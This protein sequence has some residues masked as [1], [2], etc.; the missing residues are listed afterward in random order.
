MSSV[1]NKTSD[2]ANSNSGRVERHKLAD[3]LY[4]W[5]MA[6][7]VVSLMTTAF[8]PILGIKFELSW[9]SV[10]PFI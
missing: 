8:L 6:L 7:A 1:A 9:R 2:A 5:I 10:S 3:R 4:H